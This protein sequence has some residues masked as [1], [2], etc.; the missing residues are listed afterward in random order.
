M[1]Y[2]ALSPASCAVLSRSRAERAE[3]ARVGAAADHGPDAGMV[4]AELALALPA[5]VVV[6]T[7]CLAGLGAVIDQVR[8]VDAARLAARAAARGDSPPTVQADARRAAPA[9]AAV[10]VTSV[11]HEVRVV[12]T[13]TTGGWAGVLPSF[14]LVAT[15]TTPVEVGLD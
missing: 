2:A 5:L 14:D 9:G 4:T 10:I 3:C 12:V 8:C 13:A 15:A 7:V 6:M 11:G 1:P